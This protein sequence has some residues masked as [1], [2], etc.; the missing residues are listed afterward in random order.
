MKRF[1][2]YMRH[3]PEHDRHFHFHESPPP[4]KKGFRRSR[5]E[6]LCG[7]MSKHFSVFIVIHASPPLRQARHVLYV[8]ADVHLHRDGK[9]F[10]VEVGCK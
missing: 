2:R 8:D 3:I 4:L 10:F 6:S 5:H 1:T 7:D 9:C